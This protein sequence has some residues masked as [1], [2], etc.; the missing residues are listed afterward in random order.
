MMFPLARNVLSCL[1]IRSIQQL[2]ARQSHAKHSPDFHDKHGNTVLARGTIFCI[3][4]WLFTTTKIGI[5]W[6]LSPVG[7][8]TPKEWNDE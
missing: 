7:R 6:N 2:R 4:A 3:I 8:V 5:E 1:R